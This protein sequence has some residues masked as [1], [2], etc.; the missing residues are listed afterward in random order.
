MRRDARN[1]LSVLLVCVFGAITLAGLHSG[2]AW[3]R[4][5]QDDGASEYPIADVVAAEPIDPKQI[6][7]KRAKS[8]KYKQYKNYIGPGVVRASE[9]YHWPPGFPEL[10]VVQSDA[11][12]VGEVITASAHLTEDKKAVYSEFTLCVSEIIKDSRTPLAVGTFVT[13][14][15]AGGRVRYPS[16]KIS[17]FSLDGFGMP[18]VGRRYLLFLKGDVD[19]DFQIITGYELRNGLV[20]PLDKSTSS[21]TNFDIF[22]NSEE[23]F[24]LNKV[25]NLLQTAH[26]P[27]SFGR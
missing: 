4:Q 9:I 8:E 19:Q 20:F 1:L 11:V 22:K 12:I 13:I 2:S 26:G 21:D 18:R 7:K 6:L 5:K 27:T 16:G 17:Q 14:D 15:R 25:R 10:P 3:N 23:G 24:V